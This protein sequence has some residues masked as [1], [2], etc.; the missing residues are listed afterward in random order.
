[1]FCEATDELEFEKV[2]PSLEFCFCN[3]DQSSE[4]SDADLSCV[5]LDLLSSFIASIQSQSFATS[6]MLVL[7]MQT[8]LAAPM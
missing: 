7:N 4:D 8:V 3:P 5:S 6:P 2:A 1:M